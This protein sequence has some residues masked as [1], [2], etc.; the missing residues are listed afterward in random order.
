MNELERQL[1]TI[2]HEKTTKIL[3]GNIKAGITCFD[4]EGTLIPVNNQNKKITNNGI[5]MPDEGYTGLGAVVVEIENGGDD[6]YVNEMLFYI[7]GVNQIAFNSLAKVLCI[8]STYTS[9]GGTPEE[10]CA[11]LNNILE[12]G[13]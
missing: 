3:P 1:R 13:N 9:T 11:V 7:L 2:S 5:Y 12:G 10:I 6:T 8:N 4:V